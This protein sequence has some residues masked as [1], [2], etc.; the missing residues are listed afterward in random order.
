MLLLQGC[1]SRGSPK[2]LPQSAPSEDCLL[3]IKDTSLEITKADEL[4]N[5]VLLVPKKIWGSVNPVCKIMSQVHRIMF[6]QIFSVVPM[7]FKS[8][9]IALQKFV[10]K[11]FCGLGTLSIGGFLTLRSDMDATHMLSLCSNDF[12]TA[13]P[14]RYFVLFQEETHDIASFLP[15]WF[16]YLPKILHMHRWYIY[17]P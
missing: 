3:I 8:I 13:Y 1:F 2:K 7:L 6:K 9:V 14:V 15:Q 4:K 12:S 5:I 10:W 17:S 11:W 16:V